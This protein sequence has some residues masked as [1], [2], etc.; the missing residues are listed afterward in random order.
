ME[1]WTL[2]GE[3]RALLEKSQTEALLGGI[4]D[5]LVAVNQDQ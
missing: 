3:R 2:L 1:T 4:D 5:C